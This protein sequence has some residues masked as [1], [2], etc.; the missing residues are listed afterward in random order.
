MTKHVLDC[1]WNG[2]WQ[3]NIL[4]RSNLGHLVYL[5]IQKRPLQIKEVASLHYGSEAWGY[6]KTTKC[7]LV[8]LTNQQKCVK[9][10]QSIFV[11]NTCQYIP[12][13]QFRLTTSRSDEEHSSD[14]IYQGLKR[15]RS[16]DPNI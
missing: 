6:A 12:T 13:C 11:V 5:K 3:I 14:D 1:N 7:F 10:S 8:Q 16:E 2:N 15:Y 9:W 4:L